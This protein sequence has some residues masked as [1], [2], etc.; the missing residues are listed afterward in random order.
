[1]HVLRGRTRASH[2]ID[3]GGPWSHREP[4]PDACKRASG[5]ARLGGG[6][7]PRSEQAR[8]RGRRSRG[9]PDAPHGRRS[10]HPRRLMGRAVGERSAVAPHLRARPAR[11][12]RRAHRAAARG[13]RRPHRRS[14]AGRRLRPLDAVRGGGPSPR[15][16]EVSLGVGHRAR[17]GPHGAEAM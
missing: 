8:Q 14:F 7:H 4:A 17:A 16:R 3:R 12:L 1:D 13:A 11:G 5:L 2:R 9:H 10:G 15:G 6:G